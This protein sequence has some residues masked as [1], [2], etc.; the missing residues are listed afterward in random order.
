MKNVR[1]CYCKC[2]V[3][4]LDE[5]KAHSILP[6][7]EMPMNNDIFEKLERVWFFTIQ[8]CRNLE[9]IGLFTG[10]FA[11]TAEQVNFCELW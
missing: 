8:Y 4:L 5:F 1:V 11:L 6:T 2:D 7:S 9:V 10:H 3:G